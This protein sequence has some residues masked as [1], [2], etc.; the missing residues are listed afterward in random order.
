MQPFVTFLSFLYV[1][2]HRIASVCMCACAC[3]CVSGFTKT[4]LKAAYYFSANTVK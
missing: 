1:L 4:K 2:G 3:V